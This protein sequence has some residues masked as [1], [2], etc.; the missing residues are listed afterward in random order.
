MSQPIFVVGKDR[1]GTKWLSN[2]IASHNDIA[3]VQ[4]SDAGGILES[5]T[6]SRMYNIFGTLKHEDN[7]IGF[8][9]LK[10]K[11]DFFQLTGLSK[12][13]FYSKRPIS[14]YSFFR[15]LMDMFAEK[16]NKSFWVQK[17]DTLLLDS[18][19]KEF[20]NAKF[21]LIERNPTDNI[22]STIGLRKRKNPDYPKNM[23]GELARYV[24][25]IKINK[26]YKDKKNV[27]LIDFK[28]LQTN[29]KNA[30]DRICKFLSIQ[31]NDDM[32]TDAFEKNTS[33]KTRND[34]E[35]ILNCYDIAKIKLLLPILSAIPLY[36]YKILH[37]IHLR[38]K[39]LS[40]LH[41]ERDQFIPGSFELLK[42][43]IHFSE[44][45]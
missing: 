15:E 21:V 32:L 28:D 7:F 36:A 29:R 30:V 35:K 33:F 25:R 23:L 38:L 11:T 3:C 8:L 13:L 26:L 39:P 27:M 43:E 34:K 45:K 44:N 5:N 9:E 19:Y 37:K 20:P 2:I 12:D 18:L 40:R 16:S 6:L 1:S 42:E 22:K 17:A 24:Y 4:R 14:Y 41:K 31:I 10:S